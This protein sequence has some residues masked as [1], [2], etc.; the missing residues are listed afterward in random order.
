MAPTK[1]TDRARREGSAERAG[2]RRGR[3]SVAE[4]IGRGGE[5]TMGDVDPW[6]AFFEHFWGEAAE[7][8]GADQRVGGREPAEGTRATGAKPGRRG[9]S[10]RAS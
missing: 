8:G 2:S 4:E 1:E 5:P 10:R 9:S 7:S 3:R 6:G